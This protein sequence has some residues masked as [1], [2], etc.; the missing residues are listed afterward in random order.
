M[1]RIG[2]E[3]TDLVKGV[4]EPTKHRIEGD[5]ETIKLIASPRFLQAISEVFRADAAGGFGH[6]RN[7]GQN[8]IGQD[9]ASAPG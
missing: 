5:S 9:P 7:W 1:G 8:A 3:L 4:V 2:A 6:T